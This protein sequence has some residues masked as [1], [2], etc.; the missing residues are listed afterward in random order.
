M[1]R[2]SP[3]QMRRPVM[4][5]PI[6]C[7]RRP[8][9]RNPWQARSWICWI[10]QRNP[11]PKV[12]CNSQFLSCSG[13]PKMACL[14][15]WGR[16]PRQRKRLTTRCQHKAMLRPKLRWPGTSGQKRVSARQSQLTWHPQGTRNLRQ[17]QSQSQSFQPLQCLNPPPMRSET[18]P[19]C[20]L[21]RLLPF[22][23]PLCRRPA[24]RPPRST[25]RCKTPRPIWRLIGPHPQRLTLRCLIIPCSR[26]QY[27]LPRCRSFPHLYQISSRPLFHRQ[28]H[29]PGPSLIHGRRSGV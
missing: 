13:Q 16:M 2:L 10:S 11:N 6:A 26:P 1:M 28:A 7:R 25:F 8:P 14:R 17:S 22:H 24:K 12:S 9:S 23:L 29:S 21:F 15:L 19:L 27:L 4:A 3:T 18:L 20:P 5:A